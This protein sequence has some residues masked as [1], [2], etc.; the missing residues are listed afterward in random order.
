MQKNCLE[1]E[2]QDQKTTRKEAKPAKLLRQKL[3]RRAEYK[4]YSQPQQFIFSS[5]PL[6]NT[7]QKRFPSKLKRQPQ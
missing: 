7:L 3:C 5:E 6:N 1:K 4:N 2:T